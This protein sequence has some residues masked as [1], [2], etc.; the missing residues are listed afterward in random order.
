MPTPRP[1]P[2]V[3]PVAPARSRLGQTSLGL[4]PDAISLPSLP[5]EPEWK[6]QQRL[7]GHAFHPMC[8]YLA[9]F[10][11]ALPMP[12]SPA[13]RDPATSSSTRSAAAAPRRSR[14]ARR[15]GSGSAIDLNPIADL[16][17]AAKVDAADPGGRQRPPGPRST[18]ASSTSGRPGRTWPTQPS[19]H[20]AAAG[21]RCPRRVEAPPRRRCPARGGPGVPSPDV[22]GAPLPAPRSSTPW[23]GRRPWPTDATGSSPGPLTGHP[24]RQAA[25]PTCPTSCPTR[26]AWRRATSATSSPAPISDSPERDVFACLERQAQRRLYRQAVP[27]RPGR[28]PARR[29]PRRRGAG[30]GGAAGPRPARPR[31]PGRDLARPTCAS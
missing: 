27:P 12:S 17:T 25:R 16:L 31:P 21:R 3:T 11:A 13:T 29:R 20:P 5:L 22:R 14:P 7:W 4:V 30:P 15:A 1:T 28:R 26:S 8:S 9:S 24:A 6:L 19:P 2:A 10:P 18:C 23:T